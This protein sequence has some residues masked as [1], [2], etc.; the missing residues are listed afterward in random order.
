MV[1]KFRDAEDVLMEIEEEELSNKEKE[2]RKLMQQVPN[3][4]HEN[5]T[6]DKKVYENGSFIVLKVKSRN[7]VGYI[8]CNTKK[9][10]KDGGHTDL[11]SLRM[12][13]TIIDNVINKRT[14]KTK[15]I[16]L[17]ESHIRLSND[18]K[19]NRY[20]EDLIVARNTRNVRYVNRTSDKKR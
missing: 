10:F 3:F 13:K 17:L 15:N 5:F 18:E 12:A 6:C 8:A 16:Y 4:N 11:N 14:P 19:Y 2:Y 9:I 20:I 1:K 7:K